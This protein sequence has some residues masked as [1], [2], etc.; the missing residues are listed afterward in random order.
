MKNLLVTATLC[1]LISILLLTT[2]SASMVQ[3]LSSGLICNTEM[4]GVIHQEEQLCLT[5]VK[6][7]LATCTA[8]P[9]QIVCQET[10]ENL[11]MLRL[12]PIFSSTASH[13]AAWVVT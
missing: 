11:S 10:V 5:L 12:F 7:A 13:M 8:T 6:S 4:S 9:A 1:P 3:L 2:V